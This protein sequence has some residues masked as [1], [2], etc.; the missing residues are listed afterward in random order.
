V[1][2]SLPQRLQVLSGAP[3]PARALVLA[4]LLARDAQPRQAQ[5]ALLAAD[6][7]GNALAVAVAH[8]AELADALAPLQRLP[9]V[10]QIFPALRQLPLEEQRALVGAIA[11]LSAAD[12][13]I[14]V[15]EFALGKLVATSLEEAL[16]PRAPHGHAT[17][18]SRRSQI[19]TLFAVL[20]REGAGSAVEAQRAYAAGIARVFGSRWPDYDCPLVWAP[21]LGKAL[22]ELRALRPAAKEPLIEGL[23]ATIS[24]DGEV[25]A[26]ESDLLRAVCAVLQ[27]PLPVLLAG[28]ALG[29][30]DTGDAA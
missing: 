8:A 13:R 4:L 18:E 22:D 16:R 24:H 5:L 10:L 20:A 11:K 9:A 28:D 29:A 12:R 23:L 19:A 26:A 25:R 7:G 21:V 1:R 27:C 14:D 6:S 2:A 3:E 30:G 15:F 17:L